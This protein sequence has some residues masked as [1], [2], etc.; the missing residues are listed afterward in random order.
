MLTSSTDVTSHSETNRYFYN[1]QHLCAIRVAVNFVPGMRQ[2]QNDC[3]V[4]PA[5]MGVWSLV[6]QRPLEPRAIT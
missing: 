6:H 5:G 3:R 2:V 4:Q 1:R